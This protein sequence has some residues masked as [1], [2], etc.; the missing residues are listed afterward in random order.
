MLL[1]FVARQLGNHPDPLMGRGY[2]NALE[3]ARLL[4]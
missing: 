4:P 2:L 1:D 3:L